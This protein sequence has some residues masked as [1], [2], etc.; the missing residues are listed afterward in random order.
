MK[1]TN[2]TNLIKEIMAMKRKS[3]NPL[4]LDVVHNKV[5]RD[6]MIFNVGFNQCIDQVILYIRTSERKGVH[7]KIQ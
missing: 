6:Q 4:K 7:E 1:L 3:P 2:K 5:E